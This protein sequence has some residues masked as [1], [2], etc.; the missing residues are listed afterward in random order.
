M[1]PN[2]ANCPPGRRPLGSA[3]VVFLALGAA[4][5]SASTGDGQGG[6]LGSGGSSSSGGG[7][8]TGGGSSG[9]SGPT[10]GTGGGS[11]GGSGPTGGTGGGSTGGSGVAGASGGSGGRLG[12]GGATSTGGASQT[13]GATGTGGSGG[14][15]GKG[16]GAGGGASGSTGG[17]AGSAGAGGAGDVVM[18]TGCRKTPP[19]LQ[20]STTNATTIQ[21][22]G[23]SRKYI[24]W[25]P[26]N[27]DSSRPYR[28]VLSYH[29]ATGS[30]S[31]VVDCNTESI[32]CYTTQS[33][34][35]GLWQLAN[36]ST[37]FVA[38]D[39]IGGLWSN[40]NGQDVTFTEDILKK[41]EAEYCVDTSRVELEGFSMG[42]AM[43]YTLVCGHPNVFRAAVVHSGGGQPLPTTCQ[44]IAYFSSLGSQESGGQ[45]STSDFFAKTDWC[46]PK[47]MPPPPTG[48]HVCTNYDGCMPGRP[49]RWC[50][51]D[52]GHTPSP[53]DSG[54]STTWMPQEVW[55]FLTQF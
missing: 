44:P 32:K 54:K 6:S 42:G 17:G 43:T 51:F 26:K 45:T 36:D 50:P 46:M 41:V 12:T 23:M 25:T 9:G 4:C 55:T 15:A 53:R 35:F 21:S 18:S 37:I 34:F 13:G 8:G 40:T 22:S 31:Q 47:T 24:L 7:P 27:Y 49:V 19:L 1:S 16:G 29:W 52:G 11:S 20:N 10:G 48:G 2:F 5:S 33:P 38:P 28:L 3:L 30:A 39:G 14:A